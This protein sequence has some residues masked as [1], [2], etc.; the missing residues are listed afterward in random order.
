MED[1]RRSG[2]SE[3]EAVHEMV[4]VLDAFQEGNEESA[5]ILIKYLREWMNDRIPP[6]FTAHAEQLK[7]DRPLP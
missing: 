4:M 5:L 7:T 2:L 1:F 3:K 6:T